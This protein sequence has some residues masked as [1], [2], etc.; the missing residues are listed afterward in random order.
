MKITRLILLLATMAITLPVDA[1]PVSAT[2]SLP[3]FT[4]GTPY[5]FTPYKLV[6]KK[7]A[8][9]GWKAITFKGANKCVW[10]KCADFDETLLC[11]GIGRN[12]CLY[13]WEK[14]GSKIMVYGVGE[15]DQEFD[16]LQR[17]KAIVKGQFGWE[18]K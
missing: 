16:E 11:S 17:C 3:K 15:G 2:Y 8:A 12:T 5:K 7:L 9:G 14:R 13:A 10:G 18:C 6:Q 1:E 4:A